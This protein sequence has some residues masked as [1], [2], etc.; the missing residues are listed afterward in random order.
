MSKTSWDIHNNA[1]AAGKFYGTI[2]LHSTKYIY[3]LL[4]FSSQRSSTYEIQL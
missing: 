2:Y 4:C 1:I 3:K